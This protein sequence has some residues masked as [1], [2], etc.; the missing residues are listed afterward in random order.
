MP[1]ARGV[2]AWEG[3]PHAET[4]APGCSETGPG[5]AG[6]QASVAVCT[7]G[8]GHVWLMIWVLAQVSLF[9]ALVV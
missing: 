8:Q 9:R 7:K 4:S 2:R 6:V 3:E 1:A 5:L